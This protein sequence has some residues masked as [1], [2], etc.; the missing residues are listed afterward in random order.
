MGS[1]SFS[2]PKSNTRTRG[3]ISRNNSLVLERMEET[4]M[5]NIEAAVED[6]AA[7]TLDEERKEEHRSFD[8]VERNAEGGL[9]TQKSIE[10]F[11]HAQQ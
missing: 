7:P 10:I 1:N 6:K 11:I 2:R 4:T 8:Y 3:D 5:T 9:V